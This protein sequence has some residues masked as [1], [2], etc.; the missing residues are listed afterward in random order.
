MRASSGPQLPVWASLRSSSMDTPD[1]F[2]ARSGKP[3]ARS[4]AAVAAMRD[5]GFD[6]E[7][8]R[9][10]CYC[11]RDRLNDRGC[12]TCHAGDLQCICM[13]RAAR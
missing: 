11:E 12:V 6:V 10:S 9:A 13:T 7:I 8:L 2:D 1:S 3:A 5:E 4:A